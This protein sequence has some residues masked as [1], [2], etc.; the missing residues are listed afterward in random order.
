MIPLI[1]AAAGLGILLLIAGSKSGTPTVGD[2]DFVPDNVGNPVRVVFQQVGP[3]FGWKSEVANPDIRTGSIRE[4]KGLDY[5]WFPG[6]NAF[7]RV[8]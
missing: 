8:A 7:V 5:T 1:L 6:L 4:I 2:R 3:G